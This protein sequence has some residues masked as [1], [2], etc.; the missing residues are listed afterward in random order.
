MSEKGSGC[1]VQM[2]MKRSLE[3][4]GLLQPASLEGRLWELWPGGG[5]GVKGLT[6]LGLIFKIKN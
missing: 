1:S 4:R 2:R 5:M 3:E 6:D